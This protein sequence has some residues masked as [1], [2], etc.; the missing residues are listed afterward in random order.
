MIITGSLAY[1]CQEYLFHFLSFGKAESWNTSNNLT[2]PA[3]TRVETFIESQPGIFRVL[4]YSVQQHVDYFYFLNHILILAISYS[5]LVLGNDFGHRL[6]SCGAN[7]Y[8]VSLKF[9]LIL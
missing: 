9:F 3:K 5:A 7:V 4:W 1:L 8:S 6:V 2:A